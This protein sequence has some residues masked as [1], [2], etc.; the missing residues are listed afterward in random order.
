MQQ[1]VEQDV[2]LRSATML[3]ESFQDTTSER[4]PR[5]GDSTVGISFLLFPPFLHLGEGCRPA[6]ANPSTL[7]Y[8]NTAPWPEP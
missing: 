2:A 3:E 6:E 8:T 7:T 5:G 4:V 1:L